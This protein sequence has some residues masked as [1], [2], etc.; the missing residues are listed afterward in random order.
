M[1]LAF[2]IV[3]LL[4]LIVVGVVGLWRAQAA[5][6]EAATSKLIAVRDIKATQIE[7]FFDE[8]V[9]DAHVLAQNPSIVDGMRSLNLVIQSD[10]NRS[11]ATP[12]EQLAKYVSL[13]QNKSNLANAKDGSAYSALHSQLHNY[14]QK[15][16]ENYGYYDLF[17]INTETGLVEYTVAKGDDYGADLK[18]GSYANTGLGQVFQLAANSDDP[19]FATMVDF[20]AYGPEQLPASFVAAPI[21]DNDGTKL[22][23]IAFQLPV[24]EINLSHRCR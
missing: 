1:L 11:G 13:Y 10:A 20:A 23:V 8:R 22:G 24:D 5:L 21:F 7:S 9:K 6:H 15:I 19:N 4:P 2:V 16:V 12:P 18:H 3:A 14:M 17:L